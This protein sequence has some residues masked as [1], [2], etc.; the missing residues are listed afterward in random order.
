MWEHLENLNHLETQLS[1]Q[2]DICLVFLDTDILDKECIDFINN[3]NYRPNVIV[4]SSNDQSAIDAIESFKVN[5]VDYLL[6]PVT[7][8]RF[9]R[10]VDKTI[11]Y[12]YRRVDSD[13]GD[14]EVII[15]NGSS[16]VRLKPEDI[17]YIEAVENYVTLN[18]KDGKFIIHFTMKTMENQLSPGPFYQ[19]APIIYSKQEHDTN[20]T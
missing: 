16:L 10:A 9:A 2:Q 11:K 13:W 7:Y 5:V 6:K 12:F 14:D 19:S 18:T 15:K 8:S 1:K 20:R 17:I 4:V 3:I